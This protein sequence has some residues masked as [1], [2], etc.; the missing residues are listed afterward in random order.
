MRALGRRLGWLLLVLWC[1]GAAAAPAIATGE[2]SDQYDGHFR[3]YAQRYFGPDFDWRWFKAQA[4][5][6]SRLDQEAHSPAGAHGVMQL[7]PATFRQLR[8]EQP[9]FGSL[10]AAQWNIAAGIYYD[11]QHFRKWR[12]LPVQERLF[13]AFASYNAGYQRVLEAYNRVQGPVRSWLQVRPYLPSET[14][15]YVDRIRALMHEGPRGT[16]L[17]RL[18]R[19]FESEG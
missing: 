10:D 18:A 2:W 14:R 3:K 15:A 8:K 4:I 5:V 9:Y 7:M 11:R 1:A 16:P 13:L 19:L 6:E 17:L 12:G